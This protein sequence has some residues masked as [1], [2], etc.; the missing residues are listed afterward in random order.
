MHAAVFEA[1]LAI[2][3]AQSLKDK[4]MVVRSVKE[5]CRSRFGVS[6][7]ESGENDKWQRC[8]L[9]FALAAVSESAARQGLQDITDFLY[10]DGRC[11]VIEIDTLVEE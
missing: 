2:P 4:R 7:V 8:R 10:A 5:R 3:G 9:T 1:T 11:E 6:V